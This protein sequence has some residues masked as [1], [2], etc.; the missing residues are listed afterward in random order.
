MKLEGRSP[1]KVALRRQRVDLAARGRRPSARRGPRLRR[2]RPSAPRPGRGRWPA[3][4]SGRRRRPRRPGARRRSPP[5]S[6]S[7]P[8]C[9][10]WKKAC[11]PLVPA[12]PNTTAAVAR[13]TGGRRRHALAVGFHLQLLQEGGQQAQALGVGHDRADRPAQAVAVE[14]VRQGQQHRRVALQR[15]LAEVGVHGRA[16]RPAGARTASQPRPMAQDRPTADHSEKRP[17]TQSQKPNTW[18]AGTPKAWALSG[19]AE[20]AD[21]VARR[22]PS[23]QPARSQARAASALA[24]VSW[25]VKVL[26]TTTTRVG[27]GVEPGQRLGELGRSTLATKRRSI[28]G[29]QRP[30]RLPDQPRAQ[31]RAADADV[32]DGAERLAGRAAF[33]AGAHRLGE[34]AHGGAAG[35]DL[36]A[37]PARP[38]RG[39]RRRRAARSAMC[40]TARPSERLTTSPANSRARAASTPAARARSSAASSVG[41]RPGLLGQVQIAGRRRPASGAPAGRARRRTGRRCARRRHLRRRLRS[42][43]QAA[44]RSGQGVS[45]GARSKRV[46]VRL[47]VGRKSGQPSVVDIGVKELR[48]V[49]RPRRRPMS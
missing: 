12:S 6:T 38:R 1:G 29:V 48:H 22:R 3:A 33:G 32:D 23:A 21:Q 43:V 27:R 16:R 9:S 37:T 25:V 24:R 15:R 49:L 31:V 26:E 2:G 14:H 13:A 19:A 28:C 46:N 7:V 20:T 42:A 11:W 45:Q 8:W 47:R 39:S 34:G 44:S 17:P 35:L 41:Q 40:S 30:Q 18:S 36:A 10:S 5:G 4:W